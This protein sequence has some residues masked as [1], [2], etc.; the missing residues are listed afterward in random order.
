VSWC[1]RLVVV[2]YRDR[3]WK[4]LAFALIACASCRPVGLLFLGGD[5]CDARCRIDE[6]DR[7]HAD[8]YTATELAE[9]AIDRAAHGDCTCSY[10]LIDASGRKD[11]SARR[12]VLD[13]QS[14]RTCAA[15][16]SPELLR[17]LRRA[18]TIPGTI[19]R[20]IDDH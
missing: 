7:E 6:N 3:V 1:R 5:G 2:P 18:S 16:A 20:C 10:A 4:T 19:A 12:A 9:L 13:D 15:G 8:R 17:E 14:V 11:L